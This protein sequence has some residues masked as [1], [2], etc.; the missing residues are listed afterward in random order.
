MPLVILV[1]PLFYF[2]L[3]FCLTIR[4]PA[5][6][7]RPLLLKRCRP[8]H[9]KDIW[10]R[11]KTSA[12]AFMCSIFTPAHTNTGT[13]A[14]ISCWR[15][16]KVTECREE[17]INNHFTCHTLTQR[18]HAKRHK[19]PQHG[20]P[21]FTSAWKSVIPLFPIQKHAH[22]LPVMTCLILPGPALWGPLLG[23]DSVLLWSSQNAQRRTIHYSSE[24]MHG[25][26]SVCEHY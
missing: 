21:A 15:E 24:R 22:V 20:Q 10:L 26:L 11:P 5:S 19:S 6:C 3:P 23:P 16:P 18:L 4:R 9:L 12:T 8:P 1:A 13:N 14:L 25:D 2:S 7:F 17:V